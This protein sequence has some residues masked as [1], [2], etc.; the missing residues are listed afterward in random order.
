MKIDLRK[1][2]I[3]KM[4]EKL[5]KKYDPILEKLIEKIESDEKAM[6]YFIDS[7][8]DEFIDLFLFLKNGGHL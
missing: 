8:C 7:V 6:A 1:R 5:S 2:V 4:K 3:D